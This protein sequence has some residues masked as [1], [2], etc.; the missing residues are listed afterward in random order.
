MTEIHQLTGGKLRCNAKDGLSKCPWTDMTRFVQAWPAPAKIAVLRRCGKRYSLRW[1][2][3]LRPNL[4]RV[5]I[6]LA[7][8]DFI[9]RFHTLLENRWSLFEGH[10]LNT[11]LTKKAHANACIG[12]L[13]SVRPT[14]RNTAVSMTSPLN[15]NQLGERD[16]A[17]QPVG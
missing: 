15:P 17:I 8:E 10:Y 11:R 16:E 7:E 1:V 5:N 9:I 13:K 6:S 4:N 14:E 12:R 3:Y 2:T